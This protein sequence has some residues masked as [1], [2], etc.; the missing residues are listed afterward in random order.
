M[1]AKYEIIVYTSD[2]CSYCRK[3]KGWLEKN[4]IS[5]TNKNIEDQEIYNEFEN[6]NAQGIPFIRIIDREDEKEVERI[7]GFHPEVIK[8]LLNNI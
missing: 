6:Y 8:R 2:S 7:V 4:K 1:V 5:F 3:L